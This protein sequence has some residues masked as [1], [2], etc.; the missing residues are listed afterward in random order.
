LNNNSGVR[1]GPAP[2]TFCPCFCFQ[3]N[4]EISIG[5]VWRIGSRICVSLPDKLSIDEDISHINIPKQTAIPIGFRDVLGQIDGLAHHQSGVIVRRFCRAWLSCLRSVNPDI[6]NTEGLPVYLNID[7]V[8]VND[9]CCLCCFGSNYRRGRRWL[10]RGGG[11]RHRCRRPHPFT[12]YQ[13]FLSRRDQ[14]AIRKGVDNTDSLCSSSVFGG[15][16]GQCIAW[17]HHIGY[18]RRR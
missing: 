17:L 8:T 12:R 2:S 10:S 7:G 5:Y 4:E 11:R 18:R 15:D 9:L 13:Q 3:L 14:V 16:V 6:A 1:S